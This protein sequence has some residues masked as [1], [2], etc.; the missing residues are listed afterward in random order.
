MPDSCSCA[1]DGVE[2]QVDRPSFPC[3]CSASSCSNPLGR[4][5]FDFEKVRLHQE[6]ILKPKSKATTS[7]ASK[8]DT[9]PSPTDEYVPKSKITTQFRSNLSVGEFGFS[10]PFLCSQWNR[11]HRSARRM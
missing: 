1:L 2:C 5:E 4:S 11:R 10:F 8:V 7:S 3:A 6:S 9:Q